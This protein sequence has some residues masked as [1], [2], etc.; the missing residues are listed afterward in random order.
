M[1]QYY[2]KQADEV[3]VIIS[4]PKSAKSVR[5]T[6]IGTII[7]PEMSK[8]IWEIYLK[9]YR[10]KNVKVEVSSEASPITAMFKYVDDNLKD[11]NVIFGVSKKGGDE[12][13]FKS[14]MR[15][16]E[17]NEHINLL[18]PI[19]TAVEPFKDPSGK[20][21]SAT[22]I[23]DNLDKP[24]EVKT[25][26]P[27]KLSDSDKEK[28]L[29]I[30]T[31][32]PKVESIS[33]DDEKQVDEDSMEPVDE[34]ECIHLNIND[35]I[36]KTAIIRA[37]NTNQ[38]AIDDQGK[39]IPV[40]PKKFPD[41]AID[42][43]FVVNGI[44]IHIFLD[45]ETKDW[46]S[47]F[48]FRGMP[49][50]KLSPEQIGQFFNTR[51]YRLLLSKCKKEWP[52]TDEMYGD[53]YNGMLEKR[54][55]CPGSRELQ[56]EDG[57]FKDDQVRAAQK[58][59]EKLR[60]KEKDKAAKAKYTNSGRKIVSF[61]DFGVKTNTFK[62]YCWPQ[63]G[64]EFRWSSWADWRKLKPLCRISFKH[65]DYNYGVSISTYDDNFDNRGFRG[66]NLDIEPPLAWITPDECAQVM[67]LSLF[68]KFARHCV[69]RIEKYINMPTEDVLAKIN[70]P[71]KVTAGDIDKTKSIIRKV[72]N[73]A[74]K[75]CKADTFSWK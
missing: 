2:A 43:M 41:R 45:K 29:K 6:A 35:D 55:K 22:D 73:T 1:V 5:K 51:F 21:V 56:T 30:L 53:L 24:D 57:E 37:Y 32:G 17:D 67:E 72:L 28:V 36:L 65:N 39:Q 7:T 47:S 9:K 18:D 54:M 34:T 75:P 16:Y 70:N 4:A 23:R 58:K 42:I 8:Q 71:E 40:N 26:L 49:E 3:I 25:M 50:A 74:I 62:G 19:E 64:K 14:A 13:R 46:D 27:D 48:K 33:E 52:L 31:S 15:Y 38:T 66:Y 63:P 10:L 12:A 60:Q 11:V 59:R 61:S 68:K 69:E 20:A 44:E